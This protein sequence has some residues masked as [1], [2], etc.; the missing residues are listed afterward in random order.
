MVPEKTFVFTSACESVE[1]L[2]PKDYS[3]TGSIS[4]SSNFTLKITAPVIANNLIRIKVLVK[5]PNYVQSPVSMQI[6]EFSSKSKENHGFLYEYAEISNIFETVTGSWRSF[7]PKISLHWGLEAAN[8]EDSNPYCAVG[9]YYQNIH[10]DSIS[11]ITVYND[12]RVQVSVP[13]LISGKKF[14]IRIL[15]PKLQGLSPSSSSDQT[16]I[17]GNMM[18]GSLSLDPKFS[19]Y[20]TNEKKTCSFT[21]P[22][23]ECT[24]IK[25]LA[26][27]E[28]YEIRFRLAYVGY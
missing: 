25:A 7:F 28:A 17:D 22:M 11:S 13:Y 20:S 24:N 23:I 18:P 2:N 16:A 26:A 12:V 27:N 3:C 1:T 4:G 6:Y 14:K 19:D 21:Q 9:I 10:P 8:K 5:N 15:I